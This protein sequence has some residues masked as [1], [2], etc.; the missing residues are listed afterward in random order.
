[1]RAPG[2]LVA[3]A[4]AV[5]VAGCGSD[6]TGPDALQ[7][8]TAVAPNQFRAGDPV[9]VSVAVVNNGSATIT[10]DPDPCQ[11]PFTIT[12]AAGAPVSMVSRV[13][14]PV[15]ASPRALRPRE[16]HAIVRDWRGDV[17]RASRPSAPVTRSR[18]ASTGC[19]AS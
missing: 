14:Q 7:V 19:R 17:A 2:S 3:I 16:E 12:T 9:T 11:D 6:S 8:G 18:P 4:A 10:I 1:M 5:L 15:L 13:C